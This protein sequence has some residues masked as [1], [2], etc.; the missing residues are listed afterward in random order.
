MDETHVLMVGNAP[1][2]KGGITSVIQQLLAY[3]WSSEHIRMQFIPTYNAG[4]AVQKVTYFSKAYGKIKKTIREDRPDLVH[5][6]MS[7]K[8]SFYRKYKVHQYCKQFGVPDIVHLHG[9]EFKSW[10]DQSDA[11][12]QEQIRQF[13]READA[14]IVLGQQWDQAVKEIE[15]ETKTMVVQNTVAIPSET[16]QWNPQRF[17]VLFLGVLIPRKGVSDLIQAVTKLQ[18]A[19][20]LGNL[21][22]VIAGTGEEEENLKAQVRAHNLSQVI[23]FAGWTEGEAKKK[24]LQ[25]SQMLV[26]PSYHE[27]LPIA[28]LEAM[29]YGLPVAATDVGDVSMAVR[30]GENGYLFAPGDVDALAA[31]MADA[32]SDPAQYQQM[33]M[34]SKAI[35]RQDFSD[36]Q[37]F[38]QILSCY[39]DI[40]QRAKSNGGA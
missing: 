31:A 26:L 29:S 1:T 33:S 25:E 17:Q 24:L 27:G 39:R 11:S 9:S 37:Y 30:P 5:I 22:V 35:A 10:Y 7:Y 6:H 19:D 12:L 23:E 14:W 3:D 36:T 34:R 20:Q 18:S 2:V 40:L 8:G 13:L 38:S 16:A 15:P 28:V 4:N 32:A 21:H